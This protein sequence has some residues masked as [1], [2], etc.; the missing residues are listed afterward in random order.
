MAVKTT[1]SDKGVKQYVVQDGTDTSLTIEVETTLNG[2]LNVRQQYV[3]VGA[4]TFTITE[5]HLNKMLEID[6]DG[7]STTISLPASIEQGFYCM[8]RQIGSGTVSFQSSGGATI[9]STAGSSPSIS[10]QWSHT[11]FDKRNSTEWVVAGDIS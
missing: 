11:T 8:A 7:N 2:S 10:G 9:S 6:P 5:S 3:S 1:I 4:G